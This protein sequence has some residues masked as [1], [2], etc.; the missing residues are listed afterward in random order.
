MEHGVTTLAEI[1]VKMVELDPTEDKS[2]AYGRRYLKTKLQEEYEE[3]LYFTS[4]ERREDIVCLK[5][6]TNAIL[7]DYRQ[8]VIPSVHT[9]DDAKL[10]ELTISTAINLICG[11]L[12]R[13]PLTHKQ[14]PSVD[15]MTNTE[16]QLALIPDSLKQLLK[17][18]VKTDEKVAVWGQNLLKA[19]RPRSGVMPSHLGLTIQLDHKFGS[20]WLIERCHRLG[21]SE[22][23]AE[24]HR[25]KY[26]YLSVK[27]G[28]SIM[29]RDTV[30]TDEV[31]AGAVEIEEAE[32]DAVLSPEWAEDQEESN[33]DEM[34][35]DPQTS[36]LFVPDDRT[37]H[38]F[39]GDNI[40]LNI[41]SLNGNT[42]FHA[43]GIIKAT[44]PAPATRQ[45]E[46]RATIPRRKITVE[47]KAATLKAAEMKIL[48]FVPKMKVGL[49]DFQFVPVADLRQDPPALLP[50][51]IAWAAGWA[52]KNHNPAFEH[53]NWN[54]FMKSIHQPECKEKSLIEFLPIIE[55]DPNDYS[56]I[57]T[58]LMECLRSSQSPAVI[59]FDLP[60][61]LKATQIVLQ[62]ELPIITRL[63]GFHLLKSF[64]GSIGAIM[65]DSGLE[66]L[67]Q[68]VYSGS[69]TAEHIL[70][71]GA[72]AKAIRFHLLAFAGITKFVLRDVV[73]SE[74]EFKDMEDF[75]KNAK[76]EKT[77]NCNL[78]NL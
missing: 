34:D 21:Y 56:T 23:Y 59:T 65:A 28:R 53:P 41:V 78:P 3:S 24:L 54:G 43:M 4:E 42:A 13:V 8:Q 47:E 31:E 35:E 36:A 69:S 37:V 6:T 22:S 7:R 46:L 62:S 40:D 76:D 70:S 57:Y 32:V 12:A 60:I 63:G 19:Y 67:I 5:D 30:I 1:H 52:I 11:D 73:F 16:S 49:A 61:W 17:S 27:N 75:I 33:D 25:Y 64:L 2:L 39:V 48:S 29:D 9:L 18:I 51:D 10:K 50:G 20:K 14:Y 55:G 74:Q 58:T 45:D 77:G 15:S 71:G 72:Y 68:L 44:C 38:Q 26:C 66:E